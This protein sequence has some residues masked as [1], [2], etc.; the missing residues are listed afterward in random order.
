MTTNCWNSDLPA[1]NKICCVV[2]GDL[3][4]EGQRN[5][6]GVERYLPEDLILNF[7]NRRCPGS[8]IR[9][10]ESKTAG[11]APRHI[12]PRGAALTAGRACGYNEADAIHFSRSGESHATQGKRNLEGWS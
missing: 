7:K 12:Q 5:V 6:K 2:A 10:S 4:R 1:G 8:K 9:S 3:A 11:G